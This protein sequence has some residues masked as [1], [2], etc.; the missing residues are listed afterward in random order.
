MYIVYHVFEKIQTPT[1]EFGIPLFCPPK[2][3]ESKRERMHMAT[4]IPW[5]FVKLSMNRVLS[6]WTPNKVKCNKSIF[7]YLEFSSEVQN[8]FIGTFAVWHGCPIPFPKFYFPAKFSCNFY[9][10]HL[11]CITSASSDPTWLV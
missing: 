5:S 10:M 4:G 3:P 6:R 2:L 9:Q 1:K 7:F 11:S 8:I